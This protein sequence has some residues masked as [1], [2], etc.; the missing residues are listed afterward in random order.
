MIGTVVDGFEVLEEIGRGGMGVVYLA[1]QLGL[2]RLVALKFLPFADRALADRLQREASSLAELQHPNIVP[3]FTVGQHN[4]SPYYAMAYCPGGS[5]ADVG[6]AN[7]TLTTGQVCGLLAPV[8]DALAALHRRGMV[9]RDVKPSNV[10][11]SADGQPFLSDFGLVLGA[12]SSRPTTSGQMLGTLGYSAPELLS[13]GSP[14]AA[15]DVFSFGVLGYELAAA[16]A[17]FVGVHVSGVLDA[18]R[19]GDFVSLA[20]LCPHLDSGLVEL[21]ESCM[22][23]DPMA[24]PRD[25]AVV[26]NS[27]RALGPLDSVRPATR[28]ESAMMTIAPT[29]RE[30]STP[31]ADTMDVQPSPDARRRRS[32]AWIAAAALLAALLAGVGY[33]QLRDDSGGSAA[34]SPY[35]VELANVDLRAVDVDGVTARGQWSVTQDSSDTYSVAGSVEL[36]A[37]SA[38][39]GVFTWDELVPKELAATVGDL[40]TSPPPSSIVAAD[41]IL[42]YC[43]DMTSGESQFLTWRA[44]LAAPIEQAALDALA[45]S[46]SIDLAKHLEAPGGE[47]CTA[48]EVVVA[49]TGVPTSVDSGSLPAGV[50]TTVKGGRT[51][52]GGGGATTTKPTTPTTPTTAT[53]V[54]PAPQPPA[55]L[56]IGSIGSTSASATWTASP[57]AGVTYR[58]SLDGVQVGSGAI[59]TKAFTGLGI[60]TNHTVSVVAVGSDGQVSSAKT[61]NFTTTAGVAPVGHQPAF[62]GT[63]PSN[64]GACKSHTQNR[65]AAQ[66]F[67]DADSDIVSYTQSHTFN[68][69]N[70]SWSFNSSTGSYTFR[71]PAGTD[72][73]TI[74]QFTV[75]ATDSQGHKSNTLT[76]KWRM[77]GN[78]S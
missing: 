55:S 7:G 69:S 30:R 52:N 53:T 57:T 50:T 29:G 38:A 34:A 41:P 49:T 25:L 26:A 72:D 65:G 39:G 74:L 56:T 63:P 31:K 27:M 76:I 70:W 21:I 68:S 60:K 22:A 13:G 33:L 11:L 36:S 17:P 67:T 20:K 24:R 19:R 1:R 3:I 28:P 18:V 75:Y 15:S 37:T 32:P 4:G 71:A 54:K 44:A 73:G 78:C 10:L 64:G 23:A 51:G 12:A 59:F 35:P 48:D 9:H 5:L 46:W 62:T 61:A 58:V 8:A 47:P 45:D 14:T 2:D 40:A 42:R 43:L 16:R 77:T 6:R 66:Y